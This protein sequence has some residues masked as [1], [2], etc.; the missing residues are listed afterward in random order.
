MNIELLKGDVTVLIKKIRDNQKGLKKVCKKSIWILLV[1]T[2]LLFISAFLIY[3]SLNESLLFICK[4]FI[5]IIIVDFLY[6]IGCYYKIKSNN[7]EMIKESFENKR[8]LENIYEVYNDD[9]EIRSIMEVLMVGCDIS[10]KEDR[11][12][13]SKIVER[14]L[15]DI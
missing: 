13:V 15:K 5:L 3:P 7:K 9:P 14:L 8:F 12:K 4:Y 10:Y 11:I 2:I 6:V 1:G